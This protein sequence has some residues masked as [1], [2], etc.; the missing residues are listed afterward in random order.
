MVDA[1]G[2]EFSEK[3]VVDHHHGRPV[4]GPQADL[5][6]QG[7]AAV[8]RGFAEVDAQPFFQMIQQLTLSQTRI[9]CRPTGLRK[10]RL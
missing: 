4:A 8:R 5:G 6:Q 7:E 1:L 9:T 2:I 10:I 3:L